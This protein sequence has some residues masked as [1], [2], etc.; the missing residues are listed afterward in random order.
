MRSKY[1]RIRCSH[2]TRT[3]KPCRAWAVRGSDPPACVFHGGREGSA[4]LV[5]P[6]AGAVGDS[7][8]WPVPGGELAEPGFYA[9]EPAQ[10]TIDQA[11]AGL[12]HKMDWLDEIIAAT[13]GNGQTILLLCELY[14]Q[15]SSRLSRLLRDR[16]ALSGD[17][18]SGVVDAI[19]AALD[20]LSTLWE[21]EL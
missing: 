21:V 7:E 13:E 20:E 15:A 9:R 1:P 6:P 4:P 10:V 5:W 16:R 19:A 18:A 11:I 17:A 8:E 3:G 2:P 12:V 14:M